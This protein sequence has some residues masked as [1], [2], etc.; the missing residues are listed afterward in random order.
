MEIGNPGSEDRLVSADNILIVAA[1]ICG[2][3]VV[4]YYKFAINLNHI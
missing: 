1:T 4:L 3:D 2:H